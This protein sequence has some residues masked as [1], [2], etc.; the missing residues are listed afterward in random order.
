VALFI[1]RTTHFIPRPG[2]P[3]NTMFRPKQGSDMNPAR[4]EH[5][6][7]E[8]SRTKPPSLIGDESD[9]FPGQEVKAGVDENVSPGQYL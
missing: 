1:E 5:V 9:A 3:K 2:I 8:L 4:Y 7:E 6:D